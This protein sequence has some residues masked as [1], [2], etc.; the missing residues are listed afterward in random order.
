MAKLTVLAMVQDILSDMNSDEVNSIN[1]TIEAQQVA[2]II[3]TTYFEI[4]SSRDW[5]HLET[6][7]QFNA[8][9]LLI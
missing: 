7:F 5:P 9:I 2:Q 6:L 8:Y 4:I 1:D 3:N